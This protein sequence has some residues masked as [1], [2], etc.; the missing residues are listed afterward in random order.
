L[1]AEPIAASRVIL[2]LPSFVATSAAQSV[3]AIAAAMMPPAAAAITL[4]LNAWPQRLASS[5][6]ALAVTCRHLRSQANCDPDSSTTT[7]APEKLSICSYV[8]II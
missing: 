2:F 4:G 7:L 8:A 1:N 6:P 5:R 3:H